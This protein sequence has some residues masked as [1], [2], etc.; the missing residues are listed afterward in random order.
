MSLHLCISRHSLRNSISVC[1]ACE[2]MDGSATS[3]AQADKKD[4]KV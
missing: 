1:Q 3:D 2:A 4:G